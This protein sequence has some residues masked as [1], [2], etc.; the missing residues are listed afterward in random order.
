[1]STSALGSCFFGGVA[2]LLAFSSL[3]ARLVGRIGLTKLVRRMSRRVGCAPFSLRSRSP[4]GPELL[5]LHRVV[6]S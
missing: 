6:A 5:A 1:M 3:N 4:S 2:L